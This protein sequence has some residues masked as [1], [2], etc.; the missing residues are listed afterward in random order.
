MAFIKATKHCHRGSTRSDRNQLD[1][2]TPISGVYSIFKS[3]KKSSSCPNYNRGV[4]H[5]TDEKHLHNMSEY[6]VG[7]FNIAFNRYNNHFLLRIINH[8]L[9]KY[10]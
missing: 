10:L 1:M 5:Q 7:V 2:P 9:L 3:L 4:T 6:F 8:Y